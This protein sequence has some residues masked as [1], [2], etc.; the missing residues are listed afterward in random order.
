MD[1]KCRAGRYLEVIKVLLLLRFPVF[2]EPSVT[3]D[4]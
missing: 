1:L 3:T 2:L 4:L